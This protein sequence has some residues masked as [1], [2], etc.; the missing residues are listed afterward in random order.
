MER[1][2]F[3]IA[4]RDDEPLSS[5]AALVPERLHRRLVDPSVGVLKLPGLLRVRHQ[6]LDSD[7]TVHFPDVPGSAASDDHSEAGVG[8]AYR[9]VASLQRVKDLVRMFVVRPGAPVDGR[10]LGD[11]EESLNL[12]VSK[13]STGE[14]EQ[15]QRHCG[16]AHSSTPSFF[17]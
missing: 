6:E 4:F 17:W 7:A 12:L 10:I 3:V 2:T 5:A 8:D 15:K 16:C 14:R 9:G 1:R 11:D 13:N